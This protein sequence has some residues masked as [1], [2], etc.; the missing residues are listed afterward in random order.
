MQAPQS[1]L[2]H[3]EQLAHLKQYTQ[4]FKLKQQTNF[5][6]NRN[7]N[8]TDVPIGLKSK[9]QT[10]GKAVKKIALDN[11]AIASVYAPH[12]LLQNY[13]GNGYPPLAP[14]FNSGFKSPQNQQIP[15]PSPHF[16]PGD[17]NLSTGAAR[18][19]HCIT[20]LKGANN[21]SKAAYQTI[22]FV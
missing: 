13:H 2:N 18:A 22:S 1:Q 9:T 20:Q 8:F 11:S 21:T 5:P 16:V 3:Q 10:F 12:M 19:S 7:N 14:N 4:H 6:K 15:T 17:L